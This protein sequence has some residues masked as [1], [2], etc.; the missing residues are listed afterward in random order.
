MQ[1]TVRRKLAAG[2]GGIIVLVAISGAVSYINIQRLVQ[3]QNST[4]V[5]SDVLKNTYDIYAN[6]NFGNA[7]LRTYTISMSDPTQG[8]RVKKN[9][10]LCWEM[11]S[12]LSADLQERSKALDSE[13]DRKLV[14]DV[15][16]SAAVW[17][18]EQADWMRRLDS[19]PEAVDQIREA[20]KKNAFIGTKVRGDIAQLLTSLN[21]KSA[22]GDEIAAR[23]GWTASWAVL[24]S[25]VV[26]VF[27]GAVLVVILT[28]NIANPLRQAAVKIAQAEQQDDLT[29]QVR[30]ASNDEVGEICTAFNSFVH[31][32]HAAVSQAAASSDHLAKSAADLSGT[33]DGIY[34]EASGI[35]ALVKQT[36]D[37]AAQTNQ[38]MK[39]TRSVVSNASSSMLSLT[40]AAKKSAEVSREA[41]KV[42]RTINE[43]AGRTHLLSLNAAVE[44]AHAGASGGGFEIVA[45]EVRK[46]AAQA[47]EAAKTTSDLIGEIARKTTQESELAETTR[48]AF[49]EVERLTSEVEEFVAGISSSSQDQSSRIDK[50]HDRTS[51]MGDISKDNAARV[52]ELSASLSSFHVASA[53]GAIERT[54]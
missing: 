35:S 8:P 45:L 27:L 15:V 4:R 7:T 9:L 2:F 34:Q 38:R 50:I 22:E 41:Q 11:V 51:N 54:S 20:I 28:R 10:E 42:V 21:K 13:Q 14:A 1:W 30:V 3:H 23:S 47:T 49:S 12:K 6:T 39:E 17:R 18:G 48:Q 24:V 16:Q 36:A 46:L 40:E 19:S 26:V 52:Q 43:I 53:G 32:L 29:V 31:K 25:S 5:R 33:A 44:A 37:H